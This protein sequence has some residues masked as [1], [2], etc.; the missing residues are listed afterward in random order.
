[1][2]LHIE[3]AVSLHLKIQQDGLY[4]NKEVNSERFCGLKQFC[5]YIEL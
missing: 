4:N 2:S 5:K 3:G 1:V